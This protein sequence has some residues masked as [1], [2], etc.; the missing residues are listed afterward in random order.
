MTFRTNLCVAAVAALLGPAA[1]LAQL[2]PYAGEQ[3]RTI[4]SLS[5]Q[6]QRSLLAGEGAGLARAAE[7]NGYPGPAHVLEH[8]QALALTPEQH[9]AT[10]ALREA[11]KE[12][13][14]R[15]GEALVESERKLDQAFA[16]RQ[17]DAQRLS[18]LMADIAERQAAVREEHLRTHLQQ[19]ELLSPWQVRHYAVLRGYAG[20][21]GS[22]HQPSHHPAR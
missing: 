5:D 18:Q 16:S 19:T 6:E 20:G 11:H 15:L 12:R 2:S 9:A 21:H 8:A 1:V 3:A 13:A 17:I 4:K 14:S 7:L 22:Q 10:Q